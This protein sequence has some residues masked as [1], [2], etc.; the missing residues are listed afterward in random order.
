[1]L[2]SVVA[3]QVAV[4]RHF[5]GVVPEL[6]SRHH[7][8]N[9]VPIVRQALLQAAEKAPGLGGYDGLD[10]VA[11]TAGPGL[12]GSLMMGVQVAKGICLA[13]NL[14]L[15]GVNHLEAHLEAIYVHEDGKT[16]KAGDVAD[17]YVALLVSG[18]HT[19]LFDVEARGS[20]RLLGGTR[21]D[22]AGEAFDKVAKMLDLGYPGGVVIDR[23]AKDGDPNAFDFPRAIPS[24]KLLDFSFS[25]LKTAVR[26]HLGRYGKPQGSAEMADLCASVQ[27]AI[28]DALLGK[29]ALALRRTG[30]NNLV[31]VGGVAANSRLKAKAKTMAGRDG[32][33]VHVPHPRLCT[34]NAAMVAV[35]GA[36]MLE[37]GRVAGLE[38]DASQRW[39]PGKR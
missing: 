3:S 36:R 24:R 22:A 8:V 35:T 9:V 32:F 5:G 6:A 18:G 26:N 7:I 31:I 23:L 16:Q 28:V 12:V 10:G 4:H 19:L 29:A 21:D 14:P 15:I 27:E 30:K 1:V 11:V 37:Q 25:G 38:L 20:Y 13:A 34:D 2:A 17:S 33:D 39:M